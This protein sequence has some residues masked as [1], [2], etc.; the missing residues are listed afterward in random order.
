MITPAYRVLKIQGIPVLLCLRC[1]RYSYHPD[2]IRT[3]YCGHCHCFLDTW[4]GE[5]VALRRL[6][7]A[8]SIYVRAYQFQT[9]APDG[10]AGASRLLRTLEQVL[11]PSR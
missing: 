3:R 11:T 10:I 4:E 8:A 7:A 5:E 9:A 1:D 6:L 2:D